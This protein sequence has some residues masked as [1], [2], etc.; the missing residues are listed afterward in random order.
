MSQCGNRICSHV[1]IPY[2]IETFKV[3]VPPDEYYIIEKFVCPTMMVSRSLFFGTRS[4]FHPASVMPNVWDNHPFCGTRKEHI[5]ASCR[6]IALG[7]GN[8]EKKAPGK[9]GRSLP[10]LRGRKRA[11][12][13]LNF[14]PI[15]RTVHVM[16]QD[17]YHSRFVM[18]SVRI[19]WHPGE[20]GRRAQSAPRG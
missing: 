13:A 10:L 1:Q 7:H 16:S 15:L 2:E 17:L 18:P 12:S 4:V 11:P 3:P 5:H 19:A 8:C 6:P 14:T 20:L 9:I